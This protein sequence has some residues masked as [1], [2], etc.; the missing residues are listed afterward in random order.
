MAGVWQPHRGGHGKWGLPNFCFIPSGGFASSGVTTANWEQPHGM[1]QG[2]V[3]WAQP[4][5]NPGVPL[6]P[7]GIQTFPK[8]GEKGD[9]LGREVA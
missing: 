6:H 5:A 1:L 3:L 4:L 8:L 9:G 2:S 7:Q